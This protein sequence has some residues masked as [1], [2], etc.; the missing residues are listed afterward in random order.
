MAL[1]Y[2][3]E[4]G[5]GE[6]RDLLALTRSARTSVRLFVRARALLLCDTGP[7]GPA[8]TV[9]RTAAALGVSSRTIEHLKRRW[10]EQGL[11]A[12]LRREP[13]RRQRK[14]ARFDAECEERLLA[15][16]GSPP[17]PGRERWTVRLLAGKAAE[18][19]LAPRVSAM[20]VQRVLKKGRPGPHAAPPG[21][22]NGP[23][24][25]GPS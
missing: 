25:R 3:V 2:R 13:R 7:G 17:P 12:A 6:R 9:A 11:E 22:E 24:G 10:V 8:W 16:A 20:T 4:L 1:R 19:G 14:A 5:P 23:A 18:L 21:A 15:L